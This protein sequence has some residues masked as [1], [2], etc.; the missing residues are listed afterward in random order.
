[1]QVQRGLPGLPGLLGDGFRPD[2]AGE[3][4]TNNFPWPAR[5]SG[6]PSPWGPPGPPV[7]PAGGGGG[8]VGLAGEGG[9]G[10]GKIRM[11]VQ[12]D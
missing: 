9:S 3:R 8:G 10:G 2:G 12:V 5:S 6:P 1:M 7:G 11:R 4:G